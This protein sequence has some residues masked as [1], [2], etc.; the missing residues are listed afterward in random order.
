MSHKIKFAFVTVLI[1]ATFCWNFGQDKSAMKYIDE[2]N[3]D[4]EIKYLSGNEENYKW[5]LVYRSG[6]VTEA[7]L[8][9]DSADIQVNQDIET[10]KLVLKVTAD[11]NF[12]NKLSGEDGWYYV[13]AEIYLIDKVKLL[14]HPGNRVETIIWQGECLRKFVSENN[15]ELL[16]NEEIAR[17][18]QSFIADFMEINPK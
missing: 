7:L 6:I 5:L 11:N 2:I 1:L 12:K 17:I 18:V 9:L 16:K 10:P 4:V 14:E 3:F 8:M 13:N 15:V